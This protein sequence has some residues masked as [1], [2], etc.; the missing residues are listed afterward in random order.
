MYVYAYI[1][2]DVKM[3]KHSLETQRK[4]LSSTFSEHEYETLIHKYFT[5]NYC[6]WILKIFMKKVDENGG[7]VD[8]AGYNFS[9]Y[10]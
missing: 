7:S 2:V 1:F 5:L 4:M 8:D 3:I 6:H 10:K 9:L